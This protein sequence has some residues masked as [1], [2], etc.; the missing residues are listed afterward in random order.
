[1]EF[2]STTVLFGAVVRPWISFS[3]S[4]SMRFPSA[5]VPALSRAGLSGS[6][7]DDNSIFTFAELVSLAVS[8]VLSDKFSMFFREPTSTQVLRRSDQVADH[9]EGLVAHESLDVQIM[10]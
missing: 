6:L 10:N 2:L 1:M 9:A 8:T 7:R 4:L 3:F 5:R